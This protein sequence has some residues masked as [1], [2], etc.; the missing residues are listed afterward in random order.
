MQPFKL[1]SRGGFTEKSNTGGTDKDSK[2]KS[3]KTSLENSIN[4]G[5][6][7]VCLNART[8]VNIM[9]QLNIMLE[10]IDPHIIGVI[11]S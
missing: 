3:E 4:F 7:C 10:K 2:N 9:N 11:K 1:D 6:K 5:Y 8:I